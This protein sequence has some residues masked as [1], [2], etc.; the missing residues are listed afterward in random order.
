MLYVRKSESWSGI[1]TNGMAK[2]VTGRT[3]VQRCRESFFDAA[4]MRHSNC[5]VS[6]NPLRNDDREFESYP[7]ARE[8]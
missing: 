6:Q 5:N 4:P 2:S 7:G 1:R 8:P 3:L